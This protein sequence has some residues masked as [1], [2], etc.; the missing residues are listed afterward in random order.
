MGKKE[1]YETLRKSGVDRQSIENI[2]EKASITKFVDKIDCLIKCTKE[3]PF[4][5]PNYYGLEDE[6]K[7]EYELNIF[8]SREWELDKLYDKLEIQ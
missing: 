7:Y 8:L 6:D 4:Y 1:T 3:E 5:S 2:F